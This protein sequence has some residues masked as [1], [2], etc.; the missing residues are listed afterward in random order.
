MAAALEEDNDRLTAD[1]EA[2]VNAVKFAAQ[3]IHDEVSDHN[4]MLGGMVSARGS[5][6]RRRR[7]RAG[8]PRS[9]PPP[10]QPPATE[11]GL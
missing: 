6:G 1:L 10:R 5:A 8:R 11:R 9:H 3:A 4:R 2:K 7:A